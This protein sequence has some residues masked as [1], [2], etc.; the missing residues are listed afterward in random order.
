MKQRLIIF[1][2]LNGLF[3]LLWIGYLFSV[4]ILGT[5][6]FDHIIEIR[7]NPSKSIIIPKRGNI[8][9]RDQNLLVSSVKYYQVDI[10][11]E[12]ILKYCER[13]KESDRSEIFGHVARIIAANSP[14][15]KDHVL[16][17]INSSNKSVFISEEISEI[18]LYQIDNEF[19]R[20]KIPGLISNFSKTK[21]TYP[22]GKLGS[23]F[24]GMIDDNREDLEN[25]TIYTVQGISGLEATFDEYLR[26]KYGWQETIHDANNNR[27]PF[28]FLKEKSPIN[29]YS[30]ILTIDNDCQEILEESLAEG[31]KKYKAKN[32]IGIIMDPYTG[33]IMAMS[34]INE[35]DD[36][37]TSNELR[38]SAD[39]PV[40]FMFEPGSTLKPFTALLALEKN[41]YT[42]T[43]EIDCRDYHIKYRDEERVIK[44]DHKFKFLNFKDIIA[45]SSN[46]GISKI[47]DKI[48]S[49]ALYER[50]IALGYGHKTGSNIAGEA[51]GL[52]RKVKDWQGFSLHSISFG[53]EISVTAL[54]LANSYCAIANQGLVMQP[55]LVQKVV[56]ENGTV[57]DEHKAKVLRRISDKKSLE[58]LKSFLKSA[59]DY[60]TATGTKFDYLEVAGK[61]GTAEKSFAGKSGYQKE[62][63]TSVFAGF[64]PVEEPRYVIAVI[65]DEP[66][67][68]SYSY[69]ASLSTV[70]TFKKIVTRL[71]NLPDSDVIVEIKEKEKDFIF[72]PAVI[73]LT[74][75]EAENTLNKKGISYEIVE[76]NPNGIVINQF[77]KPNAA[78]DK[79]ESVIVILDTAEKDEVVDV[80][81]Y[82]MPNLK[83]MTLRKAIALAN[84]KNIRLV[85]D[86]SGSIFSQSIPPGTKIKFGERCVIKAR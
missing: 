30:L 82:A 72:A 83:G 16:D 86:G 2:I 65:Y 5:H 63:Y 32:A 75:Q 48:G 15:S 24:L 79:K 31:L 8:Y 69:Y 62:K 81:D 76:R 59:V 43:D 44:D 70:P 36:D 58:T 20:L 66:D 33:A 27:I 40:S 60:G 49:E 46:V 19:K 71:V 50:L 54:Q 61:T 1:L 85:V 10:D 47:V 57:I 6:N 64:F 25:E 52:F 14:L 26:G 9:D 21:R 56:D 42:P 7:Q 18:Q 23:N 38:S 53:Q 51:S 12:A 4:Q 80:F 45:Y 37:R 84:K 22:Q 34:G 28:L 35:Y 13:N 17:R 73:G 68:S 39:L 67:Y 29:G 77:P 3:I 41:I 55:Y 78:F 74:R 11:V